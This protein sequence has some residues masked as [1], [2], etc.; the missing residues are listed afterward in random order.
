MVAARSPFISTEL[1]PILERIRKRLL[2]VPA[3]KLHAAVLRAEGWATDAFDERGLGTGSTWFKDKF[4]DGAATV[5]ALENGTLDALEC[6]LSILEVIDRQRA[7]SE[8]LAILTLPKPVLKFEYE[9]EEDAFFV[10]VLRLRA[11]HL[12]ERNA[13]LAPVGALLGVAAR[14]DLLV[15]RKVLDRHPSLQTGAPITEALE[16]TQWFTATL[17]AD[18][19]HRDNEFA[20]YLLA[21]LVALAYTPAIRVLEERF[22]MAQHEVRWTIAKALD[23]LGSKAPR[24]VLIAAAERGELETHPTWGALREEALWAVFMEDPRTAYDKLAPYL[25]YPTLT[26]SGP[27]TIANMIAGILSADRWGKK[28]YRTMTGCSGC[29]AVQQLARGTKKRGYYEA[30][31]RWAALVERMS[32]EDPLWEGVAL[33]LANLPEAEFWRR[34][35]A[36]ERRRKRKKPVPAKKKP[37]KGARG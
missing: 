12:V 7:V 14:G 29:T 18:S 20:R 19:F 27:P 31:P 28:N 26:D 25:A 22:A 3:K 24:R 10:S 5:A 30:D 15:E 23:K 6:A 4:P 36:L 2:E 8:A 11:V 17:Q 13:D 9:F 35:A 1:A 21:R 37:R 32:A 16:K 34:M 33:N